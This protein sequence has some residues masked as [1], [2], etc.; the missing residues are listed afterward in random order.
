M[1]H[2]GGP[3]SSVKSSLAFFPSRT[4]LPCDSISVNLTA[5]LNT[6]VSPMSSL[7]Q[8][9]WHETGREWKRQKWAAICNAYRSANWLRMTARRALEWI[10]MFKGLAEF[11]YEISDLC[12]SVCKSVRQNSIESQD[13][14]KPSGGVWTLC[15]HIL[16]DLWLNIF[17]YFQKNTNIVKGAFWIRSIQFLKKRFWGEA[18]LFSG[19]KIIWDL[20]VFCFK[21]ADTTLWDQ[22]NYS[23]TLL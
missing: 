23:T 21:V 12:L 18:C 11:R 2:R 7:A 9:R 13:T 16:Y 20:H 15:W 17:W 1:W 22:Y 8:I 4:L 14:H 19:S 5:T 3:I 6:G 10:R